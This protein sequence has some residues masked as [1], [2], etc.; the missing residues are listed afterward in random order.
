[1]SHPPQKTRTKNQTN[2]RNFR[3]WTTNQLSKGQFGTG[4][5]KVATDRVDDLGGDGMD[6]LDD[7]QTNMSSE[8]WCLEDYL[9]FPLWNGSFWGDM[10]V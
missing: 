6:K 9:Y 8:K 7:I 5:L 2:R 10:L 3:N 1:M 4:H